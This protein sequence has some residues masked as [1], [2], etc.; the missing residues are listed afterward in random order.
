MAS[1]RH[2]RLCHEDKIL[3]VE[4][5]LE[6]HISDKNGRRDN[7][8]PYALAPFAAV[9][10]TTFSFAMTVM[11]KVEGWHEEK[12][13]GQNLQR[14]CG[15]TPK[16]FYVMGVGGPASGSKAKTQNHHGK[17]KLGD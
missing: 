9:P 10:K 7:T 14:V 17:C 1:S 15:S 5:A 3:S 8:P 16:P 2:E 12:W 6:D 13:V 4:Q 11:D